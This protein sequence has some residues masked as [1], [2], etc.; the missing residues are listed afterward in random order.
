MELTREVCNA[1]GMCLLMAGTV[2]TAR[3]LKM[4]RAWGVTQVV[5]A[6]RPGAPER[7]A[8][9]TDGRDRQALT[10]ELQ[11][12]FGTLVDDPRMAEIFRV[13]LLLRGTRALPPEPTP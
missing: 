3:H 11:R 10:A 8:R 4:L 2:L 1:Q 12:M 9:A 13:A 7:P 6:G 5:I